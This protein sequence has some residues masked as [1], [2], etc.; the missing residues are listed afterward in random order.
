MGTPI[1]GLIVAESLYFFIRKTLAIGM[2][3]RKRILDGIQQ[4]SG[5]YLP[6]LLGG[7]SRPSSEEFRDSPVAVGTENNMECSLRRP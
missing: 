1:L 4:A 3:V 5:C 2:R 7:R 6:Y